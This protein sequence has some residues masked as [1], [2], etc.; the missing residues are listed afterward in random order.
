[1]GPQWYTRQVFRNFVLKLEWLSFNLTTNVPGGRADNSGVL[2]RF[3]AL[4]ASDP[5]NDWKLASDEGYEIQ[6]DEM[7]FN[8]DTGQT[9]SPLHQTGV[10]YGPA[11]SSAIASKPAGQWKTLEIE[12][13][14]AAISVTL[15]GNW[16]P[17]TQ[18]R[19]MAD[20]VARDISVCSATPATCNSGT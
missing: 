10:V 6:I 1:L 14:D 17:L 16:S 2:I 19:P 7:G 12:A 9:F 18:S 4:N 20:A 11:L 3:P 15:N 8:V 5:D 13:T